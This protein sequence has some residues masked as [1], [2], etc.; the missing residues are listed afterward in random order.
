MRFW[1]DFHVCSPKH[2]PSLSPAHIQ[3]LLIFFYRAFRHDIPIDICSKNGHGVFLDSLVVFDL[4]HSDMTP[5]PNVFLITFFKSFHTMFSVIIIALI[6]IIAGTYTFM[7][8]LTNNYTDIRS[9]SNYCKH[10]KV[11]CEFL[12]MIVFGDV[13]IP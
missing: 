11:Y 1:S 3:P 6:I 7:T 8:P 12:L 2:A 10:I 13:N 9:F 4:L 5:V